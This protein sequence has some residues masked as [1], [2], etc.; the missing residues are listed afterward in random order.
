M[1]LNVIARFAGIEKIHLPKLSNRILYIWRAF[2]PISTACN[3]ISP[4]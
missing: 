2:D 4:N 1:Y 3:N